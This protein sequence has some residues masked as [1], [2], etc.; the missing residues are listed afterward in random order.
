M[1]NIKFVRIDD[2]MKDSEE[3]APAFIVS[4]TSHNSKEAL[5]C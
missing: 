3:T 5:V 4:Q 1:L 2:A